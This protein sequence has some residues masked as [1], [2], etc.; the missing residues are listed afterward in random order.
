MSQQSSWLVKLVTLPTWKVCYPLTAKQLPRSLYHAQ[1]DPFP[2]KVI[3][4]Q[5]AKDGATMQ[6]S[7]VQTQTHY[8][9]DRTERLRPILTKSYYVRELKHS[10][11]GRALIEDGNRLAGTLVMQ[12]KK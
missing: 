12:P 8:V 5:L 9:Y 6:S 10:L 3:S 11:G 2:P 7:H 4:I 1:H